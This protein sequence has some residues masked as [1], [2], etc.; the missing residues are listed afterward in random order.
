MNVDLSVPYLDVVLRA[1]GSWEEMPR[2][3]AV[4]RNYPE[5]GIVLLE[6]MHCTAELVL[7][8]DRT[9]ELTLRPEPQG[10][11]RPENWI[12]GFE[13][14]YAPE[15]QVRIRDILERHF[16]IV[17]HWKLNAGSAPN[18]VVFDD[19]AD[20]VRYLHEETR[21]GDNLWCWDWGQLLTSENAALHGKVPNNRGHGHRGGAY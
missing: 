4:T 6:Q 13:N 10:Y 7:N 3:Y 18:K 8:E 21:P 9:Y 1:D 14:L 19:Y 2:Q 15:V 16:L 17:E 5:H 20:F 12:S 11:S